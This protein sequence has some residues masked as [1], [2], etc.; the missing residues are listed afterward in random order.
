MIIAWMCL[1]NQDVTYIM[2]NV[3]ASLTFVLLSYTA[4]LLVSDMC[5]R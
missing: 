1:C 2:P 5:M 3:K 4:G